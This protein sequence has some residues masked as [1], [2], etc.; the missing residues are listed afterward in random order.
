MQSI[1]FDIITE[2]T[3]LSTAQGNSIYIQF[4]TINIDY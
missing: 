2:K 3:V 4:G 1:N